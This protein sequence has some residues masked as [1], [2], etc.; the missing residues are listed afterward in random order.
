[1][2]AGSWPLPCRNWA[3]NFSCGPKFHTPHALTHRTCTA[4]ASLSTHLRPQPLRQT[5]GRACH[6]HATLLPSQGGA[7]ARGQVPASLLASSLG[8]PVPSMPRCLGTCTKQIRNAQSSAAGWRAVTQQ[9]VAHQPGRSPAPSPSPS[10]SDH[11][12]PSTSFFTHLPTPFHTDPSTP[13]FALTLPPSIAH[14]LRPSLR[15]HPPSL[16]H[17]PSH[18]RSLIPSATHP[19]D[20]SLHPATL[21]HSPSPPSCRRS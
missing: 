21:C 4:P 1:M 13:P 5:Q 19:L 10:G 17:S 16:S 14:A 2:V 8:L 3:P 15:P 11:P 20:P 18:T 12:H 7:T 6:A 9:S